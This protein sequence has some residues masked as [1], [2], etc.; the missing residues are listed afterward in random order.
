MRHKSADNGAHGHGEWHRQHH[1]RADQFI[2]FGLTSGDASVVV[3]PLIRDR[4]A[5][6]ECRL[7]EDALVERYSFFIF[8]VV[9]AHVVQ[10]PNIRRRCTTQGTACL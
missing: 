10:S 2:N 7:H 9:Y 4:H 5:C 6:F 1:R 8:E 3:A